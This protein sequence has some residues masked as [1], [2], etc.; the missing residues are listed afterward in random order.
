MQPWLFWEPAASVSSHCWQ[1]EAIG[2]AVIVIGFWRLA[3]N[4]IEA[5][6]DKTFPLE[7][8]VQAQR[9]VEADQT[10]AELLT[11]DGVPAD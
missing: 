5:R 2:A 6:V 10:S 8:V 11:V 9:Y 7:D 1:P 4:G 3:Q